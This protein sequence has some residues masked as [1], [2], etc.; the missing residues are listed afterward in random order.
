MQRRA[1][2]AF[3]QSV[4]RDTTLYSVFRQAGERRCFAKGQMVHFQG[5]EPEAFYMIEAGQLRS[6]LLAEDGRQVTLEVLGPGKLF[7]QASYFGRVPR[8]TS[9]LAETKLEIL[10]IDY[11]RLRPYVAADAGLVTEVFDLMGYSIR[12]LTIRISGMVFLDAGKRVANALLQ[13]GAFAGSGAP[14]ISCTHQ[15][16]AELTGLNRVTVTRALHGLEKHGWLKL[17]YRAVE[18][19]DPAALG[20]YIDPATGSILPEC[21]ENATKT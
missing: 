18:L 1:A 11:E 15:E 8:L 16:L 21:H 14:V 9:A 3:G 17:S 7:G 5:D 6:F 12:M 13:L 4:G 19:R 2:F 20:R 10:A